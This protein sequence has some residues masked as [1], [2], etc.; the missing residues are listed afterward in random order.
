MDVRE[1]DRRTIK[2]QQQLREENIAEKGKKGQI[3]QK[4]RSLNRDAWV[5]VSTGQ[6]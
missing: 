1:G 4:G 6:T 5:V 3:P 2:S